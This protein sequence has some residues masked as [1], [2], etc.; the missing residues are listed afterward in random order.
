MTQFELEHHDISLVET[1]ETELGL[2]KLPFCKYDRHLF[3]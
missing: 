2:T 3:Y 1:L